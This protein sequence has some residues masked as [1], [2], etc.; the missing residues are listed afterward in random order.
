M[1]QYAESFGARGCYAIFDLFVGF[2]QRSLAKESCDLTT[3]QTPL[4]TF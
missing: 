3:F 4:G 1:E 2:D